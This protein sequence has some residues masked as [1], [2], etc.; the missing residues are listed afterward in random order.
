MT[1][2]DLLTWAFFAALG[3]VCIGMG[4]GLAFS[5]AFRIIMFFDR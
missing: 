5:L 4:V 2:V 1:P 3:L